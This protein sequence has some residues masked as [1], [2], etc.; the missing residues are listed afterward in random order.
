MDTSNLTDEELS[1]LNSLLNKLEDTARAL[2]IQEDLQDPL[3]H[4]W[5]SHIEKPKSKIISVE[6]YARIKNLLEGN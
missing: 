5:H 3:K 1:K 4:K 2:R 6:A